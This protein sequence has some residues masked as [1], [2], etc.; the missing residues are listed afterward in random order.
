L[1]HLQHL[2]VSTSVTPAWVAAVVVATVTVMA[3]AEVVAVVVA[4]AA[5]A[6]VVVTAAAMVAASLPVAVVVATTAVA[7]DVTATNLSLK[8]PS[9][10]VGGFLYYMRP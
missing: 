8:T 3:I 9:L 7:A 10:L 6:M 4:S 1:L 5:T 2:L